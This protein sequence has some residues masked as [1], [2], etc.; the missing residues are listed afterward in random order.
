MHSALSITAELCGIRNVTSKV[1]KSQM[2]KGSDV[3]IL[4]TS[5][6]MYFFICFPLFL[7]WRLR[8]CV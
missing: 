1:S 8:L 4:E 5:W 2:C 3:S 7:G 6:Y